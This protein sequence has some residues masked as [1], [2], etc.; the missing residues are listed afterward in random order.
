MKILALFAL[1]SALLFGC[2]KKSAEVP[3]DKQFMRIC[4]N[5]DPPTVDT[6]KSAEFCA[7]TLNFL[8]YDGLT[9]I[10]PDGDVELALAES[11]DMTPDGLIYTFHLRKA[12]WSDGVQITAHD[13]EY[14]W[15]K[16]LNP[17]FGSPCPHLLFSIK[18]A[19]K[20]A[21]G[22][23]PIESVGVKALDN[24]TLQVALENPTPYFLSLISFCNFYPIPRHIELQN[25]YWQNTIDQNMVTSGPFKLVKWIRNKEIWVEKNPH[26]WD[27]AQIYLP[28]IHI[29]IIPDE[30]TALQ[31][32]ENG[33]IDYISTV[34]TP[35][36][37]ED[38]AYFR[39]QG[40]LQ[41]T[42]MGGLLFCTFN[43]ELIPFSNRKIR[44]AFS[45]A[46]DRKSIIEN[47]YQLTDVPATRC[48]P[49][50]LIGMQNKELFPAKDPDLART[51]LIEGIHE[52]G[53]SEEYFRDWIAKTLALSYDGV[54]HRKIAQAI[55]QQWK[56]TLQ[57]EIKLQEND[58]KTQLDR[59]LNR[60]YSIALD[61]LIVQYNDPNNILERFKYRHMKKNL[62]GFENQKYIELLNQAAC[63]N[64]AKKR[65]ALLEEAEALLMDEMPLSPIYHFN[66]G[67]LIHPNFTH[68]EVSPLGNLLF[69]KIR[70][71]EKI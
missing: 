44:K 11:F 19:E 9:R 71:K 59:L 56:N 70:P 35:L 15:K 52:L 51:L 3:A 37:I 48:I 61:Y 58:P 68:V 32:Y 60:N 49:P 46:I 17:Q 55:Q 28:G 69:Q 26:Y 57:V 29:S 34:T 62:P 8:I 54:E 50:V 4:L 30:K 21:K 13:F 25:P 18:N 22:E 33:E 65:L 45:Y 40:N 10:K 27:A 1:V 6:R 36:S 2:Q 24:T 47:L 63:M 16:I 39:R 41:I 67:L 7:S 23:V 5:M 53:V 66:Q 14:S 43:T 12:F 64:D 38:L 31:M 20:S 42:P